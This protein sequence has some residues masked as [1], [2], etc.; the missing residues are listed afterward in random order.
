V[1]LFSTLD[2]NECEPLDLGVTQK[3]LW[4]NEKKGKEEKTHSFFMCIW[5]EQEEEG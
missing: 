4:E 5:R 2:L 3:S 1:H